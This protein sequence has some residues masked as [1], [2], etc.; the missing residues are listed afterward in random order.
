M[1]DALDE[2]ILDLI[3]T[4]LKT[5]TVANGFATTITDAYRA[6]EETPP[7]RRADADRPFVEI[8]HILGDPRWHIRGAYQFLMDVDLLLVADQGDAAIRA[9]VADVLKLLDDNTRW[10]DGSTKL[11]DRTMVTG[12]VIQEPEVQKR[13]A[14]AYVSFAVVFFADINDLTAVKEI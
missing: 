8:R 5:I 12:A 3:E 11:A 14:Q 2:Q 10:D 1:P 6:M 4:K 13:D 7:A 9:F